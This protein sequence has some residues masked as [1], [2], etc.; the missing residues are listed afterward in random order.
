MRKLKI[1]LTMT[2]IF[3]AAVGWYLIQPDVGQLTQSL[4]PAN[5]MSS[6]PASESV[7]ILITQDQTGNSRL[8]LKTEPTPIRLTRFLTDM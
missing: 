4:S 7:P 8:R 5:L 2:A 6:T 1:F 3:T